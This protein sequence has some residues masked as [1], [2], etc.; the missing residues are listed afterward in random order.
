MFEQT[1]VDETQPTKKTYTLVLSLLLQIAGICALILLPLVY[2]QVLPSAQLKSEL[3]APARPPLAA[4]AA[5]IKRAAVVTRRLFHPQILYA[6]AEIPKQINKVSEMEAPLISLS[7]GFITQNDDIRGVPYGAA[8]SVP[9][10]P[11][12]PPTIAKTEKPRGP[13]RVGSIIESNLIRKVMPVY[14]SAAKAARV[15]GVVEFTALISKEGMIE[16]LR[17][18]HGHPLLVNAAREAVLQWKYRPTLLNGQPVEV[19]TDILVKFS[20]NQ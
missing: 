9:E 1:F 19:E 13:V 20:L 4:A 12:L 5:P 8:G 17:L 6:P 14:P 18:V 3:V 10:P 11:P 2:T 15:Q 7:T 16:N